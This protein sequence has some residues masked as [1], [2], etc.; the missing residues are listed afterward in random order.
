MTR[1]HRRWHLAIWLLIGPVSAALVLLAW[2]ERPRPA[3]EAWRP[4][5]MSRN[6]R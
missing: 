1:S 6:S 3:V 4:P 5:T 2:I